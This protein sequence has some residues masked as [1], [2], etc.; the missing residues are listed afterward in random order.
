[1]SPATTEVQPGLPR[2]VEGLPEQERILWSMVRAAAEK[3]FDSVR[4]TEVVDRAGVSP[5]EF[6]ELFDSKQECQIAAYQ[7]VIDALVAYVARAF[8][9]D[10]PWPLKIKRALRALLEACS[11]EP[12]VARMA[13]IEVP[14]AGPE[15][16]RRYRDAL[17]RLVPLFREG[18]EYSEREVLPADPES[19]AV[20]G[21]EAIIHGEVAAGRT[22]EL[23]RLLPD[24]LFV[25]LVPYVGPEA[26][27][28]EARRAGSFAA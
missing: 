10:G 6:Y 18:R 15:A 16:R 3:G 27:T 4:V 14:T 12:E 23:P 21:A 17:E 2:A 11:A 19:M 8:E 28:V 9:G 20:G 22:E 5:S 26:A 24:I 13:T 1:V 25:V 7:R